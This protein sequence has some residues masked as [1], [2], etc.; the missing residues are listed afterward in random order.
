MG[1]ENLFEEREVILRRIEFND[2]PIKDGII[3]GIARK[4]NEKILIETDE[5]V[6]S[7]E[8]RKNQKWYEETI[9]KY[10]PCLIIVNKGKVS[11]ST[12]RQISVYTS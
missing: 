11:L 5:E 7:I 3:I 9:A 1:I 8:Y 4:F 12:S 2:K 10:V 6:Y